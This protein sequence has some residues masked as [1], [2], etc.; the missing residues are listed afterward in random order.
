MR[1]LRG[2]G[3]NGK[4]ANEAYEALMGGQEPAAVLSSVKTL[5]N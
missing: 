4:R 3:W 2:N 5:G 1:L